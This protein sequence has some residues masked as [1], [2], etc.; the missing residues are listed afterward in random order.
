MSESAVPDD[1]PMQAAAL[2][3]QGDQLVETLKPCFGVLADI[4]HAAEVA[5]LP[6]RVAE[7]IVMRYVRFFGIGGDGR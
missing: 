5:G 2:T 4:Y 3:A 7:Q 1:F 6:D